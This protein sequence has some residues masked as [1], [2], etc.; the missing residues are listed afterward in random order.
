MGLIWLS[1]LL[2]QIH[3]TDRVFYSYKEIFQNKLDVAV[4]HTLNEI[5]K[6][7]IL[8]FLEE[9]D[10]PSWY[11]KH[12]VQQRD[13][14]VDEKLTS[15]SFLHCTDKVR[16]QL[17]VLL[18]FFV[19][20]G[21]SFDYRLVGYD[22]LDSLISVS[23]HDNFI[24]EP[25]QMG[26]YCKN[27]DSL[28]VMSD[29]VNVDLLRQKGFKYSIL[30]VSEQGKVYADELYLFFPNLE[31]RFHWDIVVAYVVIVLLLLIL[32]YCFIVFVV[33][34]GRMR[35]LSDFRFDMMNNI[36]HELKTPVTTINLAVQLLQ[37]KS[38]QKD[39]KSTEE[40][41]NIISE[42]SLSLQNLIDEVLTVFRSEHMPKKDVED[43]HVHPLIKSVVEIY[44]LRLQQCNAV[45][46]FDFQA[47]ADLVSGVG[48]HLSNAFSNL[49]DNAIKYRQ[50]DL[51][52][53]IA[54]R[55]VDNTIEI[56]FKD[57]G[58][59][60][61]KSAQQLIFEPFARANTEDGHYVKGYGLG[62]NYVAQIMSYHKGSIKVESERGKG[63]IFIVS[64]PLKVK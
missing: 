9:S 21:S 7:A 10:F 18:D 13:I 58:I 20:T 6:K 19:K 23:L 54:T 64:L 28:H 49:I 43:V 39:E 47:A 62:L 37:D 2:A 3:L 27:V 45:V 46:N 34:L 33:I 42:E 12:V 57:N 63:A 36:T 1:L 51:V 41:L 17:D 56:R 29:K 60:I 4:N 26:V 5:E 22:M 40:C 50:G 24:Y 32:L 61:D 14:C 52:I 15:A 59:G 48:I 55:N 35:K 11:N 38:I 16:F 25:F 8:T 44:Q 31:Y 53:D 30:C